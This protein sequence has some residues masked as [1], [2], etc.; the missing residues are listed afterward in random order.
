MKRFLLILLFVSA[1]VEGLLAQVYTQ[2]ESSDLKLHSGFDVGLRLSPRWHLGWAEEIYM[3]NDMRDRDRYYSRVTLTYNNGRHLQVAPMLL[4]VNIR[5]SASPED[6]FIADLNFY[7]T[8]RA[9]RWS[10]TLREAPR[11]KYSG[12]VGGE[13]FEAA[14]EWLLRSHLATTCRLADRVTAFA[15][16][17]VFNM[18]SAP[19]YIQNLYIQR[20]RSNVGL[21]YAFD[22]HN[23]LSLYWRYDHTLSKQATLYEEGRLESVNTRHSLN[24]MVGVFYYLSF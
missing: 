19:H 18:L 13:S 7:Y 14:P 9:G 16:A 22:R 20:F 4:M 2:S 6:Q 8:I 10:F 1:L 12:G 5:N 24:N 17:E 11:L 15:N 3:K 21:K 23:A